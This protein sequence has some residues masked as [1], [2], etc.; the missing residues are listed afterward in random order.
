MKRLAKYKDN[1][2][3][4]AEESSGP[5]E[6]ILFELEETVMFF[7]LHR[8]DFLKIFLNIICNIHAIIF[9]CTFFL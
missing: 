9:L 6:K 5:T 3:D 4:C 1:E 8:K 7:F 2:A